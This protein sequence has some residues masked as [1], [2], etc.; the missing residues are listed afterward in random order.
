M[1]SSSEFWRAP[2]Y[3]KPPSPKCSRELE[4]SRAKSSTSANPGSQTGYIASH[5]AQLTNLP[6][7]LCNLTHNSRV[8]QP[9]LF[10]KFPFVSID[11]IQEIRHGDSK[12][13][14]M[15][16]LIVQQKG[17]WAIKPEEICVLFNRSYR[18]EGETIPSH[19]D[20]DRQ[21]EQSMECKPLS[22]DEVKTLCDHA[23][24][25]LIEEWNVQPVKCPVT[26][27]GDIHE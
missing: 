20:L 9:I 23:R 2:Q 10:A 17:G 12:T 6:V 19:A 8:N 16:F 5:S 25:I 21:N 22:E 18:S 13:S 15:L 14:G 7:N 4:P 11:Q 26:V 3:M 24:E 1:S 27:C